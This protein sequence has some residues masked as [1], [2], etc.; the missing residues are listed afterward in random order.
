M[1]G[2]DT[3][4][5]TGRGDILSF[6]GTGKASRFDSIS[7]DLARNVALFRQFQI[8]FM[9]L[10]HVPATANAFHTPA[11]TYAYELN[12]NTVTD[13]TDVST[14]HFERF[15]FGVSYQPLTGK[16]VVIFMTASGNMHGAS[17]VLQP[18]IVTFLLE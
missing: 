11:L 17:P 6:R 2:H 15:D 4:E 12:H 7:F 9:K 16:T 10:F 3:L 8:P 18:D 5:I 14:L 1:Y 13:S